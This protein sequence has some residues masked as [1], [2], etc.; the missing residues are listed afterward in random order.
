[1]N[2]ILISTDSSSDLTYEIIK[3]YNLSVINFDYYVNEN[4]YGNKGYTLGNQEFYEAMK[5]GADVK[6]T[7][8]NFFDAKNYLERLYKTGKDI[9]HICFSSGLSGT[10]ENFVKASKALNLIYNNKCIVVD[11]LCAAGGEGLLTVI[12]CKKILNEEISLEDLANY[13]SE[14]TMK[15]NHIFTVDDLKYLVKGGRVSKTSA[16]IANFLKIKPVLNIDNYGKLAVANKVFGRKMA[17]KKLFD[18]MKNNYNKEY[19]DVFISHALCLEDAKIL[20]KMIKDK[21]GIDAKI[22]ALSFVIGCH[23]GPGTLALFYI[24]KSR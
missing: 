13:L 16:C 15:L 14:I 23:S 22:L 10:Y 1:M 12:A 20:A 9:L 24:G 4:E 8:I 7:Q 11:S 2:N 21:L 6:T 17:I 5:K 3:E 18:T 19:K